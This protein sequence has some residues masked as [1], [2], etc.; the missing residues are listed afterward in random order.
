MASGALNLPNVPSETSQPPFNYPSGGSGGG[1]AA[2]VQP[3][4]YP[5][6]GAA[7]GAHPPYHYPPGAHQPYPYPAQGPP[8]PPAT[9]PTADGAAK[10]AG[11]VSVLCSGYQ[12]R[13]F[14]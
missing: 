10:P 1:G 4:N 9:E 8:P 14:S 13:I 12:T 5:T 7:S 3:F 2:G 6:A 11:Q